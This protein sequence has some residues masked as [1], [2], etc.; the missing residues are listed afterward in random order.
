MMK[1]RIINALAAFVFIATWFYL[2]STVLPP[3]PLFTAGAIF[4]I[5]AFTMMGWVKGFPILVK[6][7]PLN[8]RIR[9]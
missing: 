8:T 6:K 5:P 9:E 4:F 3:H 7:F 1:N 2:S